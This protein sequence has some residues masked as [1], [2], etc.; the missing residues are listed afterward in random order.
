MT[1]CTMAKENHKQCNGWQNT[2]EK[3]KDLDTW[4]TLITYI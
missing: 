3:D 4:T 2:A 1:H